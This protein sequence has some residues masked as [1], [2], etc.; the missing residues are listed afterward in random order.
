MT[1]EQ[2]LEAL[3]YDKH[4]GKFYRVRNSARRQIGDEAGYPTGDGYLRA[5]IGIRNFFLHR[6]A[7]LIEHGEWPNGEI[8]HINGDRKD[9]RICNLRLASRSQN[10]M[11]SRAK[12]TNRLG[13]KGVRKMPSGQYQ[14]R[15]RGNGK[16]YHLGTFQTLPEAIAAWNAAA[17]QIHGEFKISQQENS[18]GLR[19]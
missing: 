11:N 7:W 10:M 4:T 14:T 9:N 18:S 15:I 2:V 16:T 3:A 1:L 17:E 13:V 8:D 12:S 5:K 19:S 6:L